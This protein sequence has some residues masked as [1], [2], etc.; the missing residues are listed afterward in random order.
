MVHE[1]YLSSDLLLETEVGGF[2]VPEGE[3]S[4]Y[5]VHG[6]DAMHDPSGESGGEVRNQG[7]GV[8]GFIILG[9]DDV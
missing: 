1:S 9:T 2:F 5:S 7:G 6:L 3:S 8:F 4:G